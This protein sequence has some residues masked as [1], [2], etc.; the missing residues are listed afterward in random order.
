VTARAPS[1]RSPRLEIIRHI[2]HPRYQKPNGPVRPHV[3]T[4]P[5]E[6][7]VKLKV[8]IAKAC[9][10]CDAAERMSAWQHTH[11][12]M[13]PLRRTGKTYQYISVQ[14]SALSADDVEK[15]LALL[16]SHPYS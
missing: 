11:A 6:F 13:L 1:L 10:H 4:E 9:E 5:T 3:M 15:L 7:M 8:Q 14:V 2:G 12:K 16:F